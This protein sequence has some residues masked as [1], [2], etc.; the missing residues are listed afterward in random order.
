MAVKEL[1]S[2]HLYFQPIRFESLPTEMTVHENNDTDFRVHQIITYD[3]N[4]HYQDNVT[5]S[6]TFTPFENNMFRLDHD[7]GYD[8]NCK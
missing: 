8:Y 2:M 6:M 4:N 5:C 1:L 7:G 3:Y